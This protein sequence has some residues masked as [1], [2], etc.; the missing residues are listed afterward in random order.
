MKNKVT[1]SVIIPVYK[2]ERY[3]RQ[4]IDSVLAQT[5][6]DFEL[7]LIDDGSPDGCPAIC[8]EYAKKDTRI[9]VFHKQNGGLSSARNRGIDEAH[10]EWVIF[11]DSDDAWKDTDC[12][13]KLYSYAKKLN[14]DIVRFEYQAVN[15]KLEHIE[16]RSYD[17]SNIEGRVIDNY[18]LVNCGIS[19][20]WFPWLYLI[21]KEAIGN[22]KF[23]EQTK[24][25]ED[26]DFYSRLFASS[27]L[28]C[29]YIDDRMYLYRKRTDSITNTVQISNLKGSL[30]LC[31]VFYSES[32]KINDKRLKRLY[33]Y[34][35]LKM[36]CRTLNTM[37]T[38]EYFHLRKEMG[39]KLGLS[40]MRKKALMRKKQN[41]IQVPRKYLP[42]L[43]LPPTVSIW[44][45]NKWYK[46]ILKLKHKGIMD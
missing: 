12:L 40:N 34:Y 31:D 43:Y 6:T 37:A 17:K 13:L 26:F 18:E 25:Q 3:I 27:E 16:P 14:L 38:D 20:E 28:R 22:L 5:F 24:F 36:Y 42:C 19:G 46:L 21:R 32:S 41:S 15:E 30:L 9:R 2:V 44:L 29:G 23:N 1:V 8:D 4:C 11:I 33:V 39:P 45:T 10:G 35:S 7:L